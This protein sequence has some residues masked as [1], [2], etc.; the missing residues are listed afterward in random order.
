MVHP[1]EKRYFWEKNSQGLDLLALWNS[2]RSETKGVLFSTPL[3]KKR[4]EPSYLWGDK[5]RQLKRMCV[6]LALLFDA[7]PTRKTKERR[8]KSQFSRRQTETAG[9][10]CVCAWVGGERKS[11]TP[12]FVLPLSK[13][14]LKFCV[15]H[16][17]VSCFSK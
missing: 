7:H 13:L 6:L 15:V 17:Y 5:H 9:K 3:R 14:L 10:D 16:V 2:F 12:S 8:K 1:A 4:R 11:P